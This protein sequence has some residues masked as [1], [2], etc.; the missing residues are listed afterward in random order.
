MRVLI[1]RLSSF[2]DVVF[3]LPAA[4][5]LK[6]AWPRAEVAWAVE[7]PFAPLLEGAPYVDHVLTATTRSWRR[8][9][10]AAETRAELSRFLDA[11]RAFA[12]DVV[13]DAQGLAKS[14]SATQLVPA[15]RTVGF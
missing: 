9:P 1:V 13:V 15:R 5:A 4:K 7:A 8:A 10:F 11:A 2:G 14:A 3:T 12:P 6:R